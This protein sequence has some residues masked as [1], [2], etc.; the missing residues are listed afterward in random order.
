MSKK[1]TYFKLAL[2]VD[3]VIL[4]FDGVDIRILLIKR[5]FEPF[6]GKWAL[7]G[8]L[9]YP[10]EDLDAAAQRVLTELTGLHDVFLEQVQ[11]FGTV[12][13]HPVGRVITIAY[14]SLINILKSI[15]DPVSSFATSY[16]WHKIREVK[17]LAFDHMDILNACFKRLQEKVRSKPIGFELLPT[18]F[19]LSE[20]RQLYEAILEKELDKRNFRKKI[21]SKN[22][23]IDLNEYQIGVAHRPAKL[24]S[25]DQ[26]KYDELKSKG[27]SF[28]V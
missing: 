25:F 6:A 23:L 20:L 27:F 26:E 7:T 10:H 17:D 11:T 18:K 5:A 15:P 19:T 24:F 22:L 1:D 13:R 3:N 9:V 2:S 12:E 14:Y 21:L 28:E 4:G 8:D 16:K